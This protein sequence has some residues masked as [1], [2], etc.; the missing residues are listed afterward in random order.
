MIEEPSTVTLT[1]NDTI[2]QTLIPPPTEV[3]TEK[4]ENIPITELKTRIEA[5]KENND[6]KGN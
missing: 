5:S 6:D 2:S 3:P 4:Q 1:H